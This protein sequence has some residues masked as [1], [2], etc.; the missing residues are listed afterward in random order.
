M[1]TRFCRIRKVRCLAVTALLA[2][3]AAC[4]TPAQAAAPAAPSR[5]F[6]WT[7]A[8]PTATVHL[9]GSIHLATPDIYPLDPRIEAAFQ[10]AGTLVLELPLDPATQVRAAARLAEAG[11]YSAGDTIELHLDRALLEALQERLRRSGVA[12]S[13][14]RSQRPWFLALTLS[15]G[16][17]QR[18]GFRPE[19]GVDLHLAAR[20]QGKRILGLETVDEQVAL[21]AGMSDALQ[22]QMLQDSLEHL[23]EV[24]ELLQGTLTCW[25]AGDAEG[26]YEL[27][28]APMRREFPGIYQRL[29][30]GR[31][32]RM[33]AAIEGYLRGRGVTF[34]VVGSGHLGG[35]DGILSLLRAKGYQPVQP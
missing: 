14:V 19:L 34:V 16:E 4:S 33:A 12:F 8:S 30:A 2:L 11:T 17:M 26:M 35:P 27:L 20:A 15:L 18:L 31:N 10:A 6:L 7:V 24:G 28:M 21:F 22:A 5:P 13:T 23:E 9:L 25:R 29:V 1:V 32:R 3:L